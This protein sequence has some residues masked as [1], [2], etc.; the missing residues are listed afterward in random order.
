MTQLLKLAKTLNKSSKYMQ[1]F[2]WKVDITRMFLARKWKLSREPNENS[3]TKNL[4]CLFLLK[5]IEE[6]W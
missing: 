4:E 1:W 5:F 3:S 2:I 6:A